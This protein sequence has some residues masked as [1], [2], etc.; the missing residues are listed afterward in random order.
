MANFASN[1]QITVRMKMLNDWIDV[2][3]DYKFFLFFF[4]FYYEKRTAKKT[5]FGF[6]ASN[7][8]NNN[9]E[10][11]CTRELNLPASNIFFIT[12]TIS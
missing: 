5:N 10:T 11:V 1:T 12:V 8:E 3:F 7:N 4:H 6:S 9:T 2:V